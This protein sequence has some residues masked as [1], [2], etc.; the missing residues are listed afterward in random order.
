MNEAQ[1]AQQWIIDWQREHG[2]LDH[3]GFNAAQAA[4][5]TGA[6][7]ENEACLQ[8]ARAAPPEG[9]TMAFT[10]RKHLYRIDDG[11][12]DPL[13]V[14]AETFAEAV[15]KFQKWDGDDDESNYQSVAYMGDII[16]ES[17]TRE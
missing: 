2:A 14:Q 13:F 4:Y 11:N 8:V 3:R 5:A 7:D 12:G 16:D 15:A 1:R 9:E 10:D 6:A 17:K